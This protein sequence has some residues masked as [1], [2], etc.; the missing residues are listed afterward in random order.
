[1]SCMKVGRKIIWV[2]IALFSCFALLSTAVAQKNSDKD[3]DDEPTANLNFVILKQDNGKPVRNAA[4]V[5]H[6]VNS[7]GKQSNGDLEL[8]TDLDGKASFDGVPYGKLRVQVFA[9]GF[10]SFGQDYD[11]HQANINVTIKLNRPEGQYS[12]YGNQSGGKND[13]APS[14]DPNAKPQ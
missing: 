14:P 3:E 13:K 11:V 4:V 2:S 10:Q 8:K 9:S 12:I 7:H 1:M 5:M 6:A